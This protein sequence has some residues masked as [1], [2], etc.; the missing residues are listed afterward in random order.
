LP[1]K[2][3]KEFSARKEMSQMNEKHKVFFMLVGIAN[4]ADSKFRC[5]SDH[6]EP[7]PNVPIVQPLGSVQAVYQLYIIISPCDDD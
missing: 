5:Q 2:C 3:P 7:V 4:L 6:L 1:V